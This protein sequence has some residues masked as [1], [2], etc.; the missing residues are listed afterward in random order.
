MLSWPCI[1]E[2]RYTLCCI[3][4]CRYKYPHPSALPMVRTRRSP[5]PL[6]GLTQAGRQALDKS[7]DPRVVFRFR[8][9]T[10]YPPMSACTT[11]EGV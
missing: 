9:T 11:P 5:L 2:P 6:G 4:E 3:S 7:R 8:I 1:G 10:Y